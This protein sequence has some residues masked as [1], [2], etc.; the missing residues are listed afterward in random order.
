MRPFVESVVPLDGKHEWG[1]PRPS[2]FLA[3][4][5]DRREAGLAHA[6][7]GQTGHEYL[8]SLA[9]FAPC[10]LLRAA[11]CQ[12]G[13]EPVATSFLHVSRIARPGGCSG[14]CAGPLPPHRASLSRTA[15]IRSRA[16]SSPT[17]GHGR[18]HLLVCLVILNSLFSGYIFCMHACR[19][20]LRA[21]RNCFSA[22]KTTPPK[23]SC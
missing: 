8:V 15:V 18:D 2:S 19:D 4:L 6:F 5:A 22:C 12:L 1:L 14:P 3:R 10:S 16:S 11:D 21:R 20:C 17:R 23:P 13:L 7:C 9:A